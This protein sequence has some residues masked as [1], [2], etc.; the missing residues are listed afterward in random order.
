FRSLALETT[1]EEAHAMPAPERRACELDAVSLEPP[2]GCHAIKAE[3][4]V[5]VSVPSILPPGSHAHGCGRTRRL[6]GTPSQCSSMRWF[7][8]RPA[9][10]WI[11]PQLTSSSWLRTRTL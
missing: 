5:H 11:G 7:G 1:R 10:T 3:G 4:D 8:F 9:S 6:D 2:E